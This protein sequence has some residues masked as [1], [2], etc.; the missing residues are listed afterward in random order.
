MLP[1]PWNLRA[2]NARTRDQ[3]GIYPP[4]HQLRAGTGHRIGRLARGNHM[5]AVACDEVERAVGVCADENSG[6]IDREKSGAKNALKVFVK[7]RYRRRQCNFEGSDQPE[8][9]VTALNL[10]NNPMIN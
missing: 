4:P 7:P 8:R 10:R 6:W 3:R 1:A 5:H 9:P 2:G